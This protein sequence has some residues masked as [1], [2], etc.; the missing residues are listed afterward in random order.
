MKGIF[1]LGSFWVDDL[2]GLS[3]FKI[4]FLF[5]G[6]EIRSYEA[7]YATTSLLNNLSSAVMKSR[8]VSG[9]KSIQG[10]T[11]FPTAVRRRKIK[12]K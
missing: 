8:L 5:S 11:V 4:R 9:L 6:H 3:G 7:T 2:Y 10:T 1:L 12:D